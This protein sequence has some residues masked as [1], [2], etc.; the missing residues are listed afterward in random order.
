LQIAARDEILIR[1]K[2]FIRAAIKKFSIEASILVRRM[3]S[4]GVT[5]TGFLPETG[6]HPRLLSAAAD[7]TPSGFIS[8]FHQNNVLLSFLK[9]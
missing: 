4:L 8:L 2:N 5:T 7:S 9:F 1:S 3:V 6:S